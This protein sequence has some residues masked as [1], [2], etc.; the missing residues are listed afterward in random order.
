MTSRAARPRRRVLPD[1]PQ[2]VVRPDQGAA[3]EAA[4]PRRQRRRVGAGQL[5]GQRDPG[6]RAAPLH[7]GLPDHRAR[8]RLR[9]RLRLHPRRVLR[10]VRDPRQR[11]RGAARPA[12]LCGDVTI[13]VHRGAGAYIC[14]EE[15]ALLESLEGKRGQPRSKP[16]FPADRGPLRVADRRQQRRDD[17]DRAADHRDGRRGV[18]EARRRRTRAARAS[19]RSPA[20]S[21]TAATTRSSSGTSL[22]ELI[23]DLARRHP[24][25]PRAEGGRPGRLVDAGLTKDEIDVGYD[26]DSLAQLGTAMGSRR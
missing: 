12:E 17:R 26:F 18:R 23:Y 9:R 6:A 15:T 20:T 24:R 25:R 2:V 14:G 13:V 3:A 22:R 4:L 5:Q 19:S 16:P 11:A 10:P 7:R 8:D 21:S 1:G